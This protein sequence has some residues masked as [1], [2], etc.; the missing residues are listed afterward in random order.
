MNRDTD[1]LPWILGGLAISVVAAAIGFVSSS[2]ALMPNS[3]S[4][5][6]VT[7]QPTVALTPEQRASTSAVAATGPASAADL[8]PAPQ[9]LAAQQPPQTQLQSQPPASEQ[10]GAEP[11][12]VGGQ[13]WECT[14]HGIKTFSNNPCGDQST[15]V[16]VRAINTMRATPPPL[17]YPRYGAAPD[18][19]PQYADPN[20]Y[21]DQ[22]SYADQDEVSGYAGNSYAVI[23]GFRPV[24]KRRIEHPHG[25]PPHH[26]SGPPPRRN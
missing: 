3:H 1:L 6:A 18:Y 24:L 20:A 10:T 25:P 12:T 23:G 4:P 7:A 11:P 14:T 17:R 13:I 19:S 16:A 8:A 26:N 21:S 15:L 2:K 5:G 9:G 22:D